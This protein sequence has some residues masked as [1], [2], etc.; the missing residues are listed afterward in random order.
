MNSQVATDARYHTIDFSSNPTTRLR[1]ISSA[2]ERARQEWSR[3]RP[4][5]P[6]G[7]AEG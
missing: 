2:R 7:Q 3:Y 5:I 4:L 1:P 6:G